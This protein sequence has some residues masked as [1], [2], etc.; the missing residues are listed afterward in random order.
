MSTDTETFEEQTAP[1]RPELLAH[2]YRMTGSAADAEDAVQEAYLRAWRAF[3]D[4][5]G[6]SS[7]RTWMYRIATNTCLTALSSASRRVLPSGLG[8]PPGDPEAPLNQR[9]ERWLEPMPDAMMWQ[10]AA[11][12][13]EEQLLA[14]ENITL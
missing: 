10:T 2:C 14:R 3:H 9:E 8:G 5:E 13:P 12:T 1:L 11:A 4:F 6:R 7:V